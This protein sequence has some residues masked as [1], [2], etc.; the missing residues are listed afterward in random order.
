LTHELTHFSYPRVTFATPEE[1]II[2]IIDQFNRDQ[3]CSRDIDRSPELPECSEW[4]IILNVLIFIQEGFSM[5]KKQYKKPLVIY[6]DVL[7]TRAG[8]PVRKPKK[9]DSVDP[10]NPSQLFDD[11]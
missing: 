5:P 2:R 11:D 10:F 8:S 7:K 9:A 3:L 4:Y 1:S 6:R